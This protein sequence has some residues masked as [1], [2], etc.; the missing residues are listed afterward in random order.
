MA[1]RMSYDEYLKRYAPEK[2]ERKQLEQQHPRE[3]FVESD[4]DYEDR[5]DLAKRVED[6][7]KSF[8]R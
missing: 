2:W 7:R 1:K 5:L 3:P 4:A 6:F 8:C